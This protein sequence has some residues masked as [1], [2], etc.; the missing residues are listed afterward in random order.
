MSAVSAPLS[1]AA[2]DARI[3]AL[4]SS[5]AVGFGVALAG[6]VQNEPAPY[7]LYMVALIGVWALFGLTISRATVPLLVLWI[8]YL[9]GGMIS[10]TQMSD[11]RD[12]PLYLAVTAFLALTAVFVAAIVEKRAAL[13]GAIFVG[14]TLAACLTGLLGILGYFGA[15]PGAERFTLYD[16]AAGAFKDPNVFG[17]FLVLPAVWLLHGLV[18]GR[19]LKMPVQAVGLLVLS[20]AIFLS[21]SRGAWGLY[22]LS[23]IVVCAAVFLN[24]SS[25]KLR[26]RILVMALVGMGLIA[27]AIMIALQIPQVATLFETRAQLVQ[28]YDGARLGRFARY[29]LGFAL[30]M[31]HPLGIGPLVFGTIFGED[32]HNVWLKALMDYG[33]VGFAAYFTLLVLTVAAGFRILFRRRS[34]QPFL[35]C[36]WVVF[37]GHIALGTV[38]DMDHWRHFYLLMGIIWG[39]VGL[40]ARHHAMHSAASPTDSIAPCNYALALQ[41]P[42]N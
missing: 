8:V 27:V 33:W 10:M 7:E 36:A 25:N 40:E 15:F 31:E 9:I 13:L 6:F 37:V 21:F 30:A 39:C 16:R 12:T 20:F 29:G 23:A 35:L 38:I 26:L 24:S 1:R 41:R 42:T 11:L 4:V 18:T 17:P 32:T 19:L 34:W 28:D 14:W 2:I 5:V 3:V 22:A